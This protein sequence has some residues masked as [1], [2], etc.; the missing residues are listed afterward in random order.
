MCHLLPISH[1]LFSSPTPGRAAL[2]LHSPSPRVCT[3]GWAY[4]D[5]ITKISRIDRLPNFLTHGAPLARFARRSSAMRK[6][7]RTRRKTL[8]AGTR[9]SNKLNP[10]MVPGRNR[11]RATL[12]GGERS[13][14]CTF[15]APP[16]MQIRAYINQVP[17]VNVL[18]NVV[19]KD[20]SRPQSPL[21][22]WPATRTRALVRSDS[23]I[24][25]FTDFRS[26]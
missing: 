13:H 26:F 15:P 16:N 24:P 25:R 4:V 1:S 9:T 10:H 17:N 23:G 21:F 3:R 2:G 8:G 6:T 5:V 18:D 11:T 12:V 7:R 19:V 22:F 14:H 20:Q